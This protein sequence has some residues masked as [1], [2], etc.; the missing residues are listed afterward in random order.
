MRANLVAVLT[1]VFLCGGIPVTVAEGTPE[2]E[3]VVVT[4]QKREQVISDVPSSLQAFSGE[5]LEEAGYSDLTVFLR[6]IP[7]ATIG[8]N[9]GG[10]AFRSGRANL[11]SLLR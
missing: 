1:V 9:V 11:D 3:E 7:S 6:E 4:A 2:I 10:G 5:S 8:N